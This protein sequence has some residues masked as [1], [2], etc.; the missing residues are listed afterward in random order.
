VGYEALHQSVVPTSLDPTR[1]TVIAGLLLALAFQD[2]TLSEFFTMPQLTNGSSL[3][4]TLLDAAIREK[5]HGWI[6]LRHP[7]AIVLLFSIC[8]T[9]SLLPSTTYAIF[10]T[11]ER[12][13]AL[14]HRNQAMLNEAG[15]GLSVFQFLYDRRNL[16]SSIPQEANIVLHK[17]LR[18]LME[19]GS[20][21]LDPARY[22]FRSALQNSTLQSDV[23]QTLRSGTRVRWP[24]FFSMSDAAALLLTDNRGKI[25]PPPSGLTFLVRKTA[26]NQNPLFTRTFQ[27]VDICRA[28]A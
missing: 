4:V 15:L 28:H 16:L 13:I 27:G 24:E 21:T 19:M 10:K 26:L 18:R 25:F 6:K 2:L 23:L 7:P 5:Q 14:S 8:T 20:P 9:I 12:I 1:V 3:N 11:M 22:L 17:M